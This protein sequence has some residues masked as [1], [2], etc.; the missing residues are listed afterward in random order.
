[1]LNYLYGDLVEQLFR[2]VQGPVEL[3]QKEQ[4]P[5][6]TVGENDIHL[7]SYSENCL[8]DNQHK[9]HKTFRKLNTKSTFKFSKMKYWIC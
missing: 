6:N 4:I 2:W 9:L 5:M 3:T 7:I 8:K 1:M